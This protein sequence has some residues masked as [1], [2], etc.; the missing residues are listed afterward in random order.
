MIQGFLVLFLVTN[1]FFYIF[2]KFNN[3][4]DFNILNG[5]KRKSIKHMVTLELHIYISDNQTKS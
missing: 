5:G 3:A 2:C 4:Y 1:R